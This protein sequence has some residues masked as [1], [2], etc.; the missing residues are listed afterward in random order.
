M[1]IYE[2]IR[3]K[4]RRRE[5]FDEW[6]QALHQAAI[7]YHEGFAYPLKI[8]KG[9]RFIQGKKLIDRVIS[10]ADKIYKEG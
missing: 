9:K 4:K 3:N 2:K 1:V 5:S 6:K 7:D 8:E 10:Y